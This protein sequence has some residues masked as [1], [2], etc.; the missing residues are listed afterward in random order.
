MTTELRVCCAEDV[1]APNEVLCLSREA[2]LAL[3][4]LAGAAWLVHDE[5]SAAAHA[6]ALGEIARLVAK[7]LCGYAVWLL[8]CNSSWQLDSRIMRWRGLWGSLK[9]RG[10][11]L[12]PGRALP[13][14]RVLGT[15]GVRHFSALQME[16]VEQDV[17]ADLLRAEPASHLV[18]LR[19]SDEASIESLV[20]RGW[21]RP[22][23]GPSADVV[24]AVCTIGGVVLW[25]VGAFDDRE[26]GAVALA[27]E[28]II[29]KLV[30][31]PQAG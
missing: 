16:S 28:E 14:H 20:R 6:V 4:N 27:R 1:F 22:G 23:F 29:Q 15:A 24:N 25:P 9:A 17:V 10:I 26:A 19:G 21:A 18:A 5:R 2:P 3:L 7:R 8:V 13:E 30:T 12:P 31:Q 11:A